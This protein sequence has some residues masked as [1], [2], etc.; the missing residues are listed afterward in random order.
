MT[1]EFFLAFPL[2]ALGAYRLTRLLVEDVIFD[3]PR[4]AIFSR[5][6][7][8]SSKIGYLFTCYHCL[9]LWVALLV[10]VLFLLLPQ[11]M[12]VVC[13]VLSVSAVIGLIDDWKT[14]G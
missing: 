4:N 14:R 1:I 10:V 3:R 7:P 13:A 6:P 5:F 9:G 2:L 11:P 12:L 8:S